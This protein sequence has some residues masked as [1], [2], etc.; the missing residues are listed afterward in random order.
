MTALAG[1]PLAVPPL[2]SPAFDRR[3]ALLVAGSAVVWSFGGAIARTIGVDD[4]WTMVFWRSVFAG[5]FL[6]G[7][8]LLRDGPRGTVAL[9]R[10][11]GLPGLGVAGCFATASIT[12]VLA[13][14]YTTV[15]NVILV[16]AG[17]PLVAALIGWAAFRTRVSRGT[18]GAIAAV[19]AGVAVMVVGSS[20][21]PGTF[22]G[23]LLA[24]AMTVAFALAIV[25]T[26][27]YSGVRMVPA[28]CTGTVIAACVAGLNAGALAVG[29]KDLAL[30]FAF[31][32]LNLGLGVALFVTGARLIPAALSGLIGTLETVLS[33]MWVW[34]F[35]DEVPATRTLVGGGIVLS[36]L[37]IHILAESRHSPSRQTPAVPGP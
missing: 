18:W 7:F 1:T 29:A 24:L 32:A 33:P 11:M 4:S 36:A 30:L 26:R 31:G 23:N 9:F 35:H 34:I 27:Q 5:L 13:I 8:L 25:I 15:A 12:F 28:A 6:L 21:D 2:P 16:G 14:G 3:G 20:G 19:I 10:N 22:T 17:V 37:L